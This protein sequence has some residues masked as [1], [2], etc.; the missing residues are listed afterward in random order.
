MAC[1][2]DYVASSKIL[3]NNLEYK[4]QH[5]KI[6]PRA[7]AKKHIPVQWTLSILQPAQSAGWYG[8]MSVYSALSIWN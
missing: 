2:I 4:I 5:L 3:S 8:Q 1:W 7:M 6:L